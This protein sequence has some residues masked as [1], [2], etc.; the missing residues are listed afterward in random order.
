[1]EMYENEEISYKHEILHYKFFNCVE[2][3]QE[4]CHCTRK[5]LQ[6]HHDIYKE[7]DYGKNE[8]VY[9]DGKLFFFIK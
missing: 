1:M 4:R 2:H 7:Q 8:T 5:R 3:H 9:N 6:K